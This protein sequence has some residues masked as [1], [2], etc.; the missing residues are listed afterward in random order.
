[1]L[2]VEVVLAVVVACVRV[3]LTVFVVCVCLERTAKDQSSYN[4]SE[5]D[6]TLCACV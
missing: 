4:A 6:C 3:C 2:L 5:S 1:M